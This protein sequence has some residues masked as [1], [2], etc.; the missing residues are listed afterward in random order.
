RNGSHRVTDLAAGRLYLSCRP[1]ALYLNDRNDRAAPFEA[2]AQGKTNRQ[3]TPMTEI[4]TVKAPQDRRPK[5]A[6]VDDSKRVVQVRDLELT[7]DLSAM[8]D[9]EVI[10]ALQDN[11]FVPALRALLDA[12]Q[13]AKV[14]D[15]LREDGRVTLSAMA[16]FVGELFQEINP[17]S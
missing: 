14:K 12:E 1:A 6:D 5:K 8:D 4:K 15:A 16:E 9:F 2:A 3:D 7:I 11:N 13:I 17:N 10:E